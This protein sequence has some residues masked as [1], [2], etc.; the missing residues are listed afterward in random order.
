M[1]C[2][3]FSTIFALLPPSSHV[4]YLILNH[5]CTITSLFSCTV[6]FYQP[7]LYYYLPLLMYSIFLSTIFVQ[8][9]PSSHVLYLIL[10]NFC[11]ITYLFSCTVPFFQPFLYNYL[12]LL[13]Y[14]TFFS[15]MFL[16]LPPSSH[17]LYLIL[18]HFCT[19][20]SLFSSTV[21]LQ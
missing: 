9:P 17:V 8:L 15:T 20:T 6:P 2:T 1:Y 12:P 10:N 18:N 16:L 21:P 3:L 5:F 11:T 19:N 14:C 7:F 13:M 4:L